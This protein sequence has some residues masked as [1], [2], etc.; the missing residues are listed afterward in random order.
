MAAQTI[1]SDKHYTRRGLRRWLVRTFVGVLCVAAI[2]G[3]IGCCAM[4]GSR[5]GGPVSTHFNGDEFVNRDTRREHGRF[6]AFLKWRLNRNPG[7]WRQ[8][9]DAQPG[10]RPETRVTGGRVRVTFVGH[11]TALVQ[12]DGLNILTDPIWSERCSPVSW[13]GPRRARPPGIRFEDLPPIDYVVISHNHYDHLDIPTLKRLARVHAPRFIVGLGNKALLERHRIGGAVEMDWW[14]GYALKNEVGVYS[15]PAQHFSM[16]GLCDRNATLWSG[17]VIKGSGGT[18]YFAGDTGWGSHFREI[19]QR[20]GPIRL[21]LLPIGAFR[22][23]WFMSAV[24]ISPQEAVK[25]H[26]E[27]RAETSLAIHFGT[28]PLGDDGQD[29]PVE[30]LTKALAKGGEN[31]PRFWVLDFGEGRD[32]P[33]VGHLHQS[34]SAGQIRAS[35]AASN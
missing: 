18:V 25:A 24:H 4:S 12:M 11:A 29:E 16:R 1:D 6:G 9:T 2:G 22:P 30:E 5:Y 15:V 21:A 7:P 8:Y 33:A 23:R 26:H 32:V 19:G 10:P 35:S 3:G 13:A 31:P 28:F 17:Y 20:F 34:L 27:L 14:Q